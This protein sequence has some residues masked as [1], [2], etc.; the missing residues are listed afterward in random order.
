MSNYV[1][2]GG[3]CP[4]GDLKSRPDLSQA[5]SFVA[6]VRGRGARRYLIEA[7]DGDGSGKYG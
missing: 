5:V 6:N 4:A 1:V 7:C 3:L 2:R